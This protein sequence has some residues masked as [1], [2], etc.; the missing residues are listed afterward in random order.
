[1]WYEAHL[2]GLSCHKY[3]P[4]D[5]DSD[6]RSVKTKSIVGMVCNAATSHSHCQTA[7]VSVYDLTPP[8]GICCIQLFTLHS[9][10]RDQEQWWVLWTA[11]ASYNHC[12]MMGVS[13]HKHTPRH[14][15]N[16]YGSLTTTMACGCISPHVYNY[17][18]SLSGMVCR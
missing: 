17:D 6:V 2:K 15:D 18:C 14:F 1:M 5:S 4:R 11:V 16:D 7:L 3:T 10:R 9:V 8:L 13:C 12:H